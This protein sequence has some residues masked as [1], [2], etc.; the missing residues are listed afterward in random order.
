MPICNLVAPCC[1]AGYLSRLVLNE[2]KIFYANIK[3]R[4]AVSE[5]LQFHDKLKMEKRFF[6]I[7]LRASMI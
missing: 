5:R 7:F 3:W 6:A 2:G 1:D 4:I